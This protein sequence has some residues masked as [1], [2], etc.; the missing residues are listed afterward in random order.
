MRKGNQEEASCGTDP[1]GEHP[2]AEG[3][4][5]MR[6]VSY[7]SQLPS[8][9][10]LPTHRPHLPCLPQPI[11]RPVGQQMKAKRSQQFDDEGGKDV[12]QKHRLGSENRMRPQTFPGTSLPTQWPGKD[13]NPIRWATHTGS[14]ITQVWIPVPALLLLSYVFSIHIL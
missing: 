3:R 14:D 13:R 5:E 12:G 1:T 11:P 10:R 2:G 9:P 6:M 8:P 4:W 7:H